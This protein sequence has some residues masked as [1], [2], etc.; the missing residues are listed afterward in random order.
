LKIEG[1]QQRCIE[2]KEQHLN[3]ASGVA[4]WGWIKKWK[5][6][7]MKAMEETKMNPKMNSKRTRWGDLAQGFHA[8]VKK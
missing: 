1:K 8:V 3:W 6:E 4:V 2:Q 7:K 5:A